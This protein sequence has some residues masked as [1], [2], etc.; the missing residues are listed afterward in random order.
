LKAL[1]K[2]QQKTTL[3]TAQGEKRNEL[4]AMLQEEVSGILRQIKVSKETVIQMRRLIKKKDRK[5]LYLQEDLSNMSEQRQ[6]VENQLSSCE[7]VLK[8]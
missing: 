2:R 8:V 6:T 3:L 4:Y 5:I 7:N 1:S